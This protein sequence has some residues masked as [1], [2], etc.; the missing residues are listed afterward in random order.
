MPINAVTLAQD[1]IRRQSVTPDTGNAMDVLTAALEGIGFTVHQLMH[2][3]KGTDPVLNIY[4]RY[5]TTGTNLCFAG[6]TDVVP[7]GVATHWQHDPFS[8]DIEDGF[9]Y[10]RGA[11]DMKAA[12]ACFIEAAERVIT[13]GNLGDNSL[14]FLITGDEEGPCVNGTQSVL[15]WL[16]ERG[17]VIDYCIVGEPSNPHTLGEMMKIGRRGSLHGYITV[18]GTQGHVA[19]P[20]L[21]YNP[22][23]DLVKILTAL[24]QPIDEGNDHFQPSNL[25]VV[26]ISAANDSDNIIPGEAKAQFN[27]RFSSEYTP[28][29]LKTELERR[30]T[31]AGVKYEIKWWVSGDSFLTTPGLLTDAITTA[32][33]NKLGVTPQ[34]STT[35]GTS[36]ARFIKNIC[37]V[38]EFGLVGETM[39]KVD[40]CVRVDDVHALTDIYTDAIGRILA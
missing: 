35:G 3:E 5:G 19:Y 17:E 10:G 7:V 28:E 14:S 15:P 6:H 39:H 4:A 18:A 22:I 12:I 13:S 25:E 11:S 26:K 30:M 33:Q 38:V 40:E 36:D 2:Q 24:D 34:M 9:L 21:A 27:V 29:D 31:T 37:P 16:K 23:P 1:L 32:V 8:G 20:H